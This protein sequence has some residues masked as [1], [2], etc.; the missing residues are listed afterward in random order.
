MILYGDDGFRKLAS[1]HPCLNPIDSTSP[2]RSLRNFTLTIEHGSET[3][4]REKGSRSTPGRQGRWENRDSRDTVGRTK[5][6]RGADRRGQEGEPSGARRS[7]DH[8]AG[9]TSRAH[10]SGSSCCWP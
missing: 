10:R 7:I 4:A 5:A 1:V 8:G 3:K 9:G 2:W 6:Q